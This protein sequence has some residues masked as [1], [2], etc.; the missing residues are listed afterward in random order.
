M[1]T[2]RKVLIPV[3]LRDSK[4][5]QRDF[6]LFASLSSTQ[7][8][9]LAKVGDS[10]YGFS[11]PDSSLSEITSSLGLQE[12]DLAAIFKVVR[13]LYKRM[14]D[15]NINV[16]SAV[17]DI[18][19]FSKEQLRRDLEDKRD[20]LV[21]LLQPKRLYDYKLLSK[22]AEQSVL[23]I[24]T[25]GDLEFDM[26]AITDPRTDEVIGYIPIVLLNLSLEKEGAEEQTV[27][28]QISETNID[29]FL[30]YFQR[31]KQ[32]IERLKEDFRDKNPYNN[33]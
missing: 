18:C 27:T 5:F 22:T 16:E 32:I 28:L 12:R 13:F 14:M 26:R 11:I 3:S 24:I 33:L 17:S 30:G 21:H 23:P 25:S 7:L 8:E 2:E 10:E 9:S 15:E 6:K 20:N 4:G 19:E 31:A 29:I 1:A